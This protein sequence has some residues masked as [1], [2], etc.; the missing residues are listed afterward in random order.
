LPAFALLTEHVD[1]VDVQFV[2]AYDVG[3][4]V[5]DAKSWIVVPTIGL[6][7]LG[8]TVQTGAVLPPPPPPPPPPVP[9]PDQSMSMPARGPWPAV[10]VPATA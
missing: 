9:L 10:F 8:F 2:H 7:L 5:H 6:L 3:L 1:V 4:P